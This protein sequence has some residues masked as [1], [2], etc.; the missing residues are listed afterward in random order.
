MESKSNV[1]ELPINGDL[2]H[3]SEIAFR[4]GKASY[5]FKA[6]LWCGLML[7]LRR[8]FPKWI[9]KQNLWQS[10]GMFMC[11]ELITA[12]LGEVD[13]MITPY[14]LYLKLTM[15]LNNEYTNSIKPT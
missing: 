4:Y 5:D 2:S 3:V 1:C 11:T 6:L 10:S 12:I 15:E 8:W 9:P 13:S 7:T 14:Q